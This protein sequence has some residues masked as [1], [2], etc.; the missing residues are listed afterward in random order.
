VKIYEYNEKMQRELEQT[1][2]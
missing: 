1:K 2:D